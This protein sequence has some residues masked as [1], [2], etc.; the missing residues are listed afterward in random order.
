MI[1]SE[2]TYKTV[3]DDFIFRELDTIQVK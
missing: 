3:Q 2:S 1:V